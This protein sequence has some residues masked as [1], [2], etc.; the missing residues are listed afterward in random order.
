MMERSLKGFR[1]VV[2]LRLP[3]GPI[4]GLALN[5]NNREN[6]LDNLYPPLLAQRKTTG[7]RLTE[8]T[9]RARS[10]R[11][12][13]IQ[14]DP[15]IRVFGLLQAAP[16][17]LRLTKLITSHLSP[18]SAAPTPDT[19]QSPNPDQGQTRPHNRLPSHH[20]LPR[21]SRSATRIRRVRSLVRVP[22]TRDR[23]P[24][25][26]R[27]NSLYGF[28]PVGFPGRIGGGDGGA[29]PVG[30]IGAPDG[31]FPTTGF[32]MTGFA[33]TGKR[34]EEVGAF[35]ARRGDDKEG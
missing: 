15:R 1:G 20:H 35:L 31:G 10:Q 33:G 22:S 27:M 12:A 9:T 13:L 32:P 17:P 4:L 28:L 34:G 29:F 6:L 3:R 8:V 26:W 14:M 23:G 18:T 2:G 21:P 24:S 5:P 25:I 30:R 16:P 7:Q 19:P 11:V